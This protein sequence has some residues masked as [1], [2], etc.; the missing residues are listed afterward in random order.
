MNEFI[1]FLRD[2][3][4]VDKTIK[5]QFGIDEGKE[6]FYKGKIIDGNNVFILN[7]GI[8]TYTNPSFQESDINKLIIRLSINTFIY[9]HFRKVIS[10]YKNDKK[11]LDNIYEH[12]IFNNKI[13]ALNTA[14]FYRIYG[15]KFF[16]TDNLF[17]ADIK[18]RHAIKLYEINQLKKDIEYFKLIESHCLNLNRLGKTEKV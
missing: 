11:E 13:D 6:L 1:L 2:I 18:Y 10:Y 9:T 15:N 17:E 7:K 4:G 12:Y 3:F 8:S 14:Y 16:D 5:I